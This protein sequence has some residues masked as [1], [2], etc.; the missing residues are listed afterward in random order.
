MNFHVNE[1]ITFVLQFMLFVVVST[2]FCAM[3]VLFTVAVKYYVSAHT[4]IA[5][6]FGICSTFF[7][8]ILY[9]G[10]TSIIKYQFREV[11]AVL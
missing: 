7:S 6:S 1:I 5:I 2:C 4:L 10:S 8:C 3:F 11:I 9:I